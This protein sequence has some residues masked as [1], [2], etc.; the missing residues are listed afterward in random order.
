MSTSSKT[1]DADEDN[2]SLGQKVLHEL[3]EWALTLLIFIPAFYMFSFLVYEQRVIPSESMVPNLQVGDRVAVNKFAYGYSRYSMPWGAW[4]LVPGWEGRIFASQP[5]RGDVIVFMHPHTDRVMIKRLI[6]LPG[7]RVRM[8]DEQ[9]ILNGEPIERDFVQRVDYRPNGYRVHEVAREYR[10]T[11][12]DKSWLTHQWQ[13][14]SNQVRTLDTTPEFIV[15][16]GYYLFMGDNRDNSED[17]RST[18][19]HC[20]PNQDGVIDKADCTLP[21]GVSPEKA[22]VGFVP[23]ENLIGRADTVLLSTYSCA[24][25][26]AEPCMKKRLWRGL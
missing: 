25:A 6:G 11:I 15:P 14:G 17:G 4:R 23:F 26:E 5:E 9:L 21:R 22:S 10:E 7:D 20:P 12:G 18:T 13:Q 19:G 8:I 24:K 2:Q 1:T 3:K 16:E